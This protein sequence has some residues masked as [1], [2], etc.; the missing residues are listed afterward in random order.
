[1]PT[2]QF[3]VLGPTGHAP[4]YQN[5]PGP[6]PDQM[7]KTGDMQ[8]QL[9]VD[10]ETACVE[11][12][13]PCGAEEFSSMQDQ[14]ARDVVGYVLTY[15]VSFRGSFEELVILHDKILRTKDVDS[16]RI[17]VVLVAVAA[18]DE[19]RDVSRTEGEALAKEWGCLHLE[20]QTKLI[21]LHNPAEAATE[22]VRRVRQIQNLPPERT[23][24][25]RKKPAC[26]LL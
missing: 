7:L 4:Y 1:M 12:V 11:L 22:L 19:N 18:A 21:T 13:V 23:R 26:T 3:L 5:C 25:L 6:T 14:L 16:D 17:A 9:V 24:S 20:T 10:G 2:Y 8:S 15:E